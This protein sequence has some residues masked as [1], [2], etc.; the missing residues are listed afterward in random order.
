MSIVADE[1]AILPLITLG[2]GL[3]HILDH[4]WDDLYHLLHIRA[5]SSAF[6]QY[7]G[8]FESNLNLCKAT[9]WI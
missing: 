4:S 5:W 7:V 2:E 3:Y 1:R 8:I 9:H 6:G